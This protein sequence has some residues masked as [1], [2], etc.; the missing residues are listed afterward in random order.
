MDG[1]PVHGAFNE[2]A[3][4]YVE[5]D[6]GTPVQ[7]LTVILDTGSSVLGIPCDHCTSCGNRQQK[8]IRNLSL[9]MERVSCTEDHYCTQC[10]QSTDTCRYTRTYSE[11]SKL[12]GIYL[13]DYIGISTR[14]SSTSST[15]NKNNNLD[16]NHHRVRMQFGCHTTEEG[17]ILDQ[18]TDGIL[19]LSQGSLSFIQALV[20]SKRINRNTFSICMAPST[21][22]LP[23]EGNS[24]LQQSGKNQHTNQGGILTLGGI[25]PRIHRPFL[26]TTTMTTS[27]VYQSG[28][29]GEEEIEEGYTIMRISPNNGFYVVSIRGV[30]VL[31]ALKPKV[32]RNTDTKYTRYSS[33][34][35][36]LLTV[37]GIPFGTSTGG[38]GT[39]GTNTA[40]T[41]TTTT[42]GPAVLDTGSSFTYLPEGTVDAIIDTIQS[43]CASVQGSTLYC[44]GSL[45]PEANLPSA[46]TLCI[47]MDNTAGSGTL[48]NDKTVRYQQIIDSYPTIQIEF[49]DGAMY[50]IPSRYLFMVSPWTYGY[51]CLGIYPLPAHDERIV[52]GA[53]IMHG[54]DVTFDTDTE[55]WAWMPANCTIVPDIPPRLVNDNDANKEATESAIEFATTRKTTNTRGTWSNHRV[56]L[57][58]VNSKTVKQ[59]E[60][61]AAFIGSTRLLLYGA[62][63]GIFG[64]I[65]IVMART[66]LTR[67]RIA[68]GRAY[69]ALSTVMT[70]T[71]NDS[72]DD[73]NGSS[74][75]S[76]VNNRTGNK[77]HDTDNINNSMNSN[78]LGSISI[79][80]K[81]DDDDKGNNDD[82]DNDDPFGGDITNGS[83]G[84]NNG[85][86]NDDMD[87]LVNV[88]WSASTTRRP[89]G[90][91]NNK[92]N[93]NGG[94]DHRNKRNIRS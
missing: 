13:Y 74:L 15:S 82:D 70:N 20:R 24:E 35:I 8:Y 78:K 60:R 71:A 36:P 23:N 29:Y 85:N 22:L 40:T 26:T 33:N 19:G 12:E 56:P 32:P 18:T 52:L 21:V 67:Y 54:R 17:L 11:G 1:I 81:D 46:Q 31:T 48:A 50:S 3:Y 5:L 55:S 14:T 59:D 4:H 7:T 28:G 88:R 25:D 2:L 62:F 34:L 43:Y 90:N 72:M 51:A 83:S 47:N 61:E 10:T 77:Y 57:G 93:K 92:N 30:R 44:L 89:G 94:K 76:T 79:V 68:T 64:V 6:I 16:D 63:I 65:G 27:T 66:S 9:T 80:D 37:D 86:N 42:N 73:S 45:V 39:D 53:N 58:T 69:T 49:I 91:S 38:E 84:I 41:T 75:S 87:T